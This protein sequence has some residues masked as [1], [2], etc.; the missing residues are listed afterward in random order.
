M[1]G[2]SNH[3]WFRS[4]LLCLCDVLRVLINSLGELI[5]CKTDQVIQGKQR[6][7]MH[8]NASYYSDWA[9]RCAYFHQFQHVTLCFYWTTD[10]EL[11][12][13]LTAIRQVFFEFNNSWLNPPLNFSFVF[14]TDLAKR[15]HLDWP[16]KLMTSMLSKLSELTFK[17]HIPA[18]KQTNKPQ[19]PSWWWRKL[20]YRLC[21][22]CW[23]YNPS[24]KDAL[25]FKSL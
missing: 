5:W 11:S 2:E 18:N 21:N 9:R 24:F 6:V 10:E 22:P 4:F 14:T 19:C 25:K 1:P 7:H 13:P 17:G 23:S 3:R 8:I 16:T 15:A 12:S 20:L